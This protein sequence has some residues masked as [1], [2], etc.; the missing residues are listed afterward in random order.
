[1]TAHSGVAEERRSTAGLARG[2]QEE[3]AQESRAER[4][5]LRSGRGRGEAQGPALQGEA[6][7]EGG[8]FGQRSGGP[9]CQ[10]EARQNGE[11]ARGEAGTGPRGGAG[12]CSLEGGEGE[13][14]ETEEI[15]AGRPRAGDGAAEGAKDRGGAL[16]PR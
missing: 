9:E 16:S 11:G 4:E 13:R 12:T 7:V 6:G 15:R 8:M 10:G 14:R 2:S 5:V 1:M 3:G